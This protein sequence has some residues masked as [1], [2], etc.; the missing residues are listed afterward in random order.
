MYKRRKKLAFDTS[1]IPKDT[2]SLIFFMS[3]AIFVFII[4]ALIFADDSAPIVSK[5]CVGVVRIEG[6]ITTQR[7][8]PS[9]FDTG[10]PGSEDYV[11]LFESIDKKDNVKAV[12]IEINSPGGGVVPSR[13]IYEA[14]RDLKKPKV[15]YIRE[16]GASGGYYISVGADEIIASPEAITGSIGVI[17]TFVNLRE[18]FEKVGINYTSITS[19][20][21]KDLGAFYKDMTPEQREIIQSVVDEIYS[22]FYNTVK[23]RRGD[24]LRD[25]DSIADG[26]ILTGRQALKYGLVDDVGNY[27]KALRRAADLGNITYEDLPETCY[28]SPSA[29][30]YP[31]AGLF[32]GIK[33]NLELPSSPLIEAR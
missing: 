28:F 8:P 13:E 26:R 27:K 18:L 15:A 14:V 16:I 5:N 20:K 29:K 6:T 1:K 33:I 3:I 25:F 31:F 22:Q 21:N 12:L 11:N 32:S 9:L 10:K 23:E 24:K 30:E 7:V 19:G 4:F 2:K 17:T